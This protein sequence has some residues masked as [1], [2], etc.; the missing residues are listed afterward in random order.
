MIWSGLHF[1][2]SDI[3]ARGQAAYYEGFVSC[4]PK[5]RSS[6]AASDMEHLC[7]IAVEVR[8]WGKKLLDLALDHGV[9]CIS[10]LRNL[11]WVIR[12]PK[13]APS[14]CP[15]CDTRVSLPQHVMEKHTYSTESWDTLLNSLLELDPSLYGTLLCFMKLF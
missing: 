3:K 4:N 8:W 6:T 15:I 10:S 11:V 5:R 12:H 2:N 9:A 7:K 13:H 14:P 1:K